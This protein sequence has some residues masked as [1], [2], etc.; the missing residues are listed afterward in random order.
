MNRSILFCTLLLSFHFY[1]NPGYS[2]AVKRFSEDV[3]ITSGYSAFSFNV[4][5]D[6]D[7]Q[8]LLLDQA[9]LDA[10]TY[11]LFS[12]GRPGKLLINGKWLD[13]K[14]IVT[15]LKNQTDVSRFQRVNI[16]GCE[17]G[18]G[19][20][21]QAAV[22]YL[23][24]VLGVL[25]SAS[26][27]LSGKDGDW[28]LEVGTYV[29]V[30]GLEGFSGNLQCAGTVG[31][32]LDSDD[33][34]GDGIC[35]DTDIDDDNDGV[36]DAIESPGC[37]YTEAEARVIS[38]VTT[39]LQTASSISY[40]FDGNTTN[41]FSF[42]NTS[43]AQDWINKSI[44][45]I[46]PTT[47]IA[48][49]SVNFDMGSWPLSSNGTSTFKLQGWNGTSWVDLSAAMDDYPVADFSINNTEHLGTKYAKY[50]ITG[51]SG[52][53]LNAGGGVYEITLTPYQYIAS[54]Y[55]KPTCSADL[56]NDLKN[57]H[58]DLDSDGDGSSDLSES[59]VSPLTDLLAGPPANTQLDP[60]GTDAN[61]DGLNDSVDANQNGVVD[62]IS[63][64]N[65]YALNSILK[66]GEDLDGDGKTELADYDDD[67]DGI[68]DVVESPDCFYT[69]AQ[70]KVIT[71]VTTEL[72]TAASIN[73]TFDGNT[74]HQFSFA[75]TSPAQDWINKSIFEI[76]PTTPIAISSVNFDMGSWPLSTNGTSTFK[77]QGW[78]GSS[79]VDLSTAMANYPVADFSIQNTLHT[80]SKYAKY[81]ITGVSG[82]LFNAGGGVWEITL[83]PYQFVQALHPKS[84]C[85]ADTDLDGIF[86]HQDLDSDG[87]GCT[88]AVEG[89]GDFGIDDLKESEVPGGNSGGGYTGVTFG[90]D[91]NLGNVVD[92]NGVPSSANGGQTLGL[93]Q[94]RAEIGS[95]CPERELP[96]TLISF[97]AEQTAEGT[98]LVWRT[99]DE[100]DFD[101]FE[102]EYS[103]L[104][105]YGFSKI[106]ELKGGD[107]RYVYVD[108]AVRV[109]ASYYRLK[110]VDTDGTYSYSRIVAIQSR[111]GRE[112]YRVYP[113]PSNGRITHVVTNGPIESYKIHDSSGREISAKMRGQSG[114]YEFVFAAHVTPGLYV[115]TYKTSGLVV[116]QKFVLN[117]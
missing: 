58:Q 84:T 90:V 104:P 85:A 37:F 4:F 2:R 49:S 33:F 103:E 11:H 82:T 55:P 6:A 45:E 77:L 16:Y 53:L 10:H 106:G 21:G 60:A 97:N 69:E 9:D 59:G 100:K 56:D 80:S 116:S 64:Y 75:N 115:I 42:A 70:A 40:T 46:T 39:E 79:W 67:N 94:T 5:K 32:T 113:N 105:Q 88:D 34:D 86:N 92:A 52:T 63:T 117:D 31:G 48:I 3:K 102:I 61:N 83:T 72:Q 76:T 24:K 25:V 50:R 68:L 57:N 18:K 71:S 73:Y 12:H 17:F 38:L 8:K 78:D 41:Q 35:N 101:R 1:V 99:A 29:S 74:D 114:Q 98:R 91:D 44:F 110:M 111:N 15:F 13:A 43:P 89:G 96:V 66:I 7:I 23:S 36:L 27:D 81:R 109:A 93:S 87:D 28:D 19:A 14:G 95:T 65:Q 108:A 20:A 47:P 22:S 62:Y 107:S 54:A 26:D 112:L 30:K 51:V